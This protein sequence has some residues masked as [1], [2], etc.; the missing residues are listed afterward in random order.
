MRLSVQVEL[1]YDRCTYACHHPCWH[2]CCRYRTLARVLSDQW[3]SG[4]SHGSGLTSCC[5]QCWLI[6]I[7][8]WQDLETLKKILDTTLNAH[9]L[10]NVFSPDYITFVASGPCSSLSVTRHS[11]SALISL[12][13]II[14]TEISLLWTRYHRPSAQLRSN[15]SHSIRRFIVI[16]D[17]ALDVGTMPSQ[18][19]ST[20]NPFQEPKISRL[21]QQNCDWRYGNA[22]LPLLKVCS[23]ISLTV[24]T[25]MN[26]IVKSALLNHNVMKL[27]KRCNA[28][29]SILRLLTNAHSMH[30]TKDISYIPTCCKPV[31]NS[32]TRASASSTN[33]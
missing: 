27:L 32:T 8:L 30:Q 3:R 10:F 25:I 24:F 16:S 31:E 33:P 5:R 9:H 6:D 11:F 20:I 7:K 22:Y 29:F 14:S 26:N 13:T 4:W 1:W 18:G 28:T 19:L 21:Y 12:S 15:R 2:P 23:K 17:K